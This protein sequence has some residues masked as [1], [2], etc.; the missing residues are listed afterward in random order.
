ME[1]IEVEGNVLKDMT[2]QDLKNGL[3]IKKWQ[4]QKYL[5]DAIQQNIANGR[6]GRE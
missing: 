4:D 6:S 1:E 5:H 2:I 3:G